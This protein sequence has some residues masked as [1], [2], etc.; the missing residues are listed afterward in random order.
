MVGQAAGSGHGIA[1]NP[2]FQGARNNDAGRSLHYTYRLVRIS[3]D[4]GI[5]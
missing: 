3:R 4:D 5:L 2:N 1:E